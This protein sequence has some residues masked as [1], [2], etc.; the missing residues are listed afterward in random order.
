MVGFLFETAALSFVSYDAV[1]DIVYFQAPFSG[2]TF[3]SVIYFL[4]VSLAYLIYFI[5]A[6]LFI[7]KPE[8]D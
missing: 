1:F 5:F 8:S 2:G 4:F 7:G 6:D 3:W